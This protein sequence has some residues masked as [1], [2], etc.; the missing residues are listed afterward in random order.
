MVSPAGRVCPRPNLRTHSQ[1]GIPVQ[2]APNVV[3][4]R[5]AYVIVYVAKPL[6]TRAYK[7]G[8]F[9]R[10]FNQVFSGLCDPTYPTNEPP[11]APPLPL[12]RSAF[13]LHGIGGDCPV[14]APGALV[15]PH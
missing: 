10:Q 3:N 6:N 7:S 2:G 4:P 14:R 9:S 5:V 15:V 12:Q 13:S 11:F 1:S 8:D